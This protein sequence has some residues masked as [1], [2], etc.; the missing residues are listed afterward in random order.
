[1]KKY[2][3]ILIIILPFIGNS[4]EE[5]KKFGIKFSGFVKTD[6]FFDSRQTVGVREGHFMLYP[7]N[8]YMDEAGDDLMSKSK[9]T[10]LSI[11]T[12]L[13]GTITGPDALGAKTSGVIEGE[14][15][16][17]S[18]VELN[19]F[20]LRH[21]F[22]KLDWEK[23][24]LLVGQTWHPMFNTKCFPGTVSFNTGAP[25]EPFSRNPQV[26]VTQ[27]F[28]DFNASFSALS[29]RD[30]MS[31][32][33]IGVSTLYIRNSLIPEMNLTLEYHKK[34]AESGNEF[35]VGASASFLS[36]MPRTVTEEDYKTDT[37]VSSMGASL[38]F[39]FKC[40]KITFKLHEYYGGNATNLTML[41]GYGEKDFTDLT[42][43]FLEYTPTR[44]NSVWA[45]IHT[46]GKKWQY[47]LFGGYAKN[48]G[49]SEEIKGAFYARGADI[50]YVYRASGRVIFN[51]G[52]FR[53]APEIEYTAAAYAVRNDD[54]SLQMDEK[55]K[56]TESSEV[57]NFRILL[58]VYYFF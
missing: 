25:F 17:T 27:K 8:E 46:N 4:Q 2:L 51:A 58:G 41:G 11:Q 35:L 12:R 7:A 23:T 45:E 30:F 39:K 54:G 50:D 32:G 15:F 9:F 29:Q 28:G 31:T 55:G 5:K 19:G 37:R 22:V 57:A 3:L 34:N 26:R 43:G 52:K 48:L 13:K 18:N 44:N 14:F 10:M 36:I 38:F 56:I 42:K 20:R 6:L 24:Q 33:P 49:S 21:A 16:G 40:E 53:I 47:G 1:M